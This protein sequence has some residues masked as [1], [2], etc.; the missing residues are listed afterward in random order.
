MLKTLVMG[1]AAALLMTSNAVADGMPRRAVK[2]GPVCCEPN[3]TGFYI[4]VGVGGAFTV[5]EHSAKRTDEVSYYETTTTYVTRLWDLD[6]GR[7]HAFGT[8]T[9]GY[10]HMFSGH[11]VA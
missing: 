9:V 2:A 4:G 6:N 8:V 5:H 10:D 11:W 1:A 7:A 3:W